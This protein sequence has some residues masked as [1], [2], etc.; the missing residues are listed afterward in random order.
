MDFRTVARKHRGKPKK[1]D[2]GNYYLFGSRG[3]IYEWADG[4][5]VM[6]Y[7]GTP[8]QWTWTKKLGTKRGF[9]VYQDGDSEGTLLFEGE[10]PEWDWA[11]SR[12]GHRRK[13]RLS[14]EHLARLGAQ[15]DNIR[16]K[17]ER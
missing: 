10:P 13:R 14:D 16:N 15:L 17:G 11:M 12:V 9:T 6:Y 7:H 4:L 8:Q 2:D 1:G 5:Y 3:D